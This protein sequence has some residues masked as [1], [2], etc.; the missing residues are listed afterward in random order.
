MKKV[1]A[2]IVLV[3]LVVVFASVGC[4]HA[5]PHMLA[6]GAGS[7]V[8]TSSRSA[9][10]GDLTLSAYATSKGGVNTLTLYVAA[11]YGKQG[12]RCNAIAP[13]LILTHP[14]ENFGGEA[15]VAMLEEHHLTPRVGEADDI[16]NALLKVE[17]AYL[18]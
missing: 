17:A 3:A 11:Q 18:K 13:G 2:A 15:Y 8:N 16:A 7:I 4:K 5:L 12:I 6:R 1:I 10:R 14:K 9:E